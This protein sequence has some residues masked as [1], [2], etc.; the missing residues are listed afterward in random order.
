ML[1]VEGIMVTIRSVAINMLFGIISAVIIMMIVTAARS[2]PWACPRH[3]ATFMRSVRRTA[4]NKNERK[5]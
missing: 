3:S 2:T 1:I 4:K 5:A